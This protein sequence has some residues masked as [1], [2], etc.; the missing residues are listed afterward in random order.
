M[1]DV[2][3]LAGATEN[4]LQKQQDLEL[5]RKMEAIARERI[6]LFTPNGFLPQSAPRDNALH[7][8]KSG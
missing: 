6:I 3:Q 7:E 5:L 1:S 4:V 2:H 8:H